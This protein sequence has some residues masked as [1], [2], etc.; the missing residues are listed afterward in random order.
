MSIPSININLFCKTLKIKLSVNQ[1][2]KKI[3]KLKRREENS[4]KSSNYR[5]K[6][7]P[8]Q[9]FVI[10]T[11]NAS[12]SPFFIDIP[13]KD[14]DYPTILLS[15]PISPN[16]LNFLTKEERRKYTNQTV[17]LTIAV[18]ACVLFVWCANGSRMK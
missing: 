14:F 12:L 11:L 10:L 13:Q 18:R 5:L 7:R 4:D 15:S 16:F 9:R 17:I 2:K 8:I 6:K 3:I 1:K